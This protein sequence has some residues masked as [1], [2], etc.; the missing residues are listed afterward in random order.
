MLCFYLCVRIHFQI[1]SC[2]EITPFFF[3]HKIVSW[4]HIL[5]TYSRRS[6]IWAWKLT[7][8]RLRC[9]L[10][11]R[12]ARISQPFVVNLFTR[13]IFRFIFITRYARP[14]Q[15]VLIRSIVLGQVS[16]SVYHPPPCFCKQLTNR[17][18]LHAC[19]LI[20]AFLFTIIVICT[21]VFYHIYI[22]M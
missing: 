4:S 13:A 7:V 2:W 1:P 8:G 19:Y 11:S 9:M 20:I 22:A 6:F 12:S 17:R 18:C 3:I 5:I 15:N 14:H 21:I 10:F 16:T